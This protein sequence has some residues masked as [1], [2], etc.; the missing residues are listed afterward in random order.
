MRGAHRARDWRCRSRRSARR[1]RASRLNCSRPG[2][3]AHRAPGLRRRARASRRRWRPRPQPPARWRRCARPPSASA[4]GRAAERARAGG[5][6]CAK[7]CG[8]DR[9]CA[10]RAALKSAAART[11]KVDHARRCRAA[12]QRRELIVRVDDRGRRIGARPA[13]ISPS[14]RATP[15][16]RAEALEVLGAGVG[17]HARRS[18][19]ASA[20]SRATSPGA[21][22]AHLD[23]RERDARRSRR[24]SVSGTPMWLLRLPRVAR[25][26]PGLRQDRGGHLL[27]G[28]LAVAAGDADHRARELR[29]PGARGALERRLR[30]A[31]HDLRQR[32]SAARRSPRRRPRPRP[33][34][35][36]HELVAVEV[37][38]RAARRTAPRPRAC[39]SRSRR[40]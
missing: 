24:S 27:G 4:T 37:R 23:D 20:T 18:G 33:A 3:R 11:P 25:H 32:A 22:G 31:H 8:A 9:R 21:V 2:H 13:T 40:R 39:A 38:A 28:G 16:R 29:A 34:A 6:G 10:R 1:R 30:I 7:P 35:A 15:S 12:P 36:R 17:D 26:S 14:A 19:R 5:S